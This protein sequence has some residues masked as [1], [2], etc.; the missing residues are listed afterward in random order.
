MENLYSD[1]VIFLK[2]NYDWFFS[3]IGVLIVSSL[4]VMLFRKKNIGNN[5]T[6]KKSPNSFQADHISA[7]RD[8]HLHISNTPSEKEY[9]NEM[10]NRPII[11]ERRNSDNLNDIQQSI[12]NILADSPMT[13]EQLTIELGIT[14]KML[15]NLL[16]PLVRN[17]RVK[18]L[19]NGIIKIVDMSK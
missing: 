11:E 19:E 13:H 6:I 8:V 15:D 5:K 12:I 2:N 4:F 18:V 14:E 17:G 3:G 1:M 9:I 16:P 7:E 10:K